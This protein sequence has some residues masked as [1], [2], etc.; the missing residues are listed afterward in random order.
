MH[1]YI[2]F[3]AMNCEGIM[4][5]I[6]II[7]LHILH[8]QSFKDC[9]K[10]IF[11]IERE[12]EREPNSEI[13]HSRRIL[14]LFEF[15]FFKTSTAHCAQYGSFHLTVQSYIF[16]LSSFKMIKLLREKICLDQGFVYGLVLSGSG[17][18]LSEQ[19]GYG[20]MNVLRPDPESPVLKMF[21][22]FYDDF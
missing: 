1:I 8:I 19:T 5:T 4:Y 16:F 20:S 3:I 6:C 2:Y 12:R 9:I 18:I 21:H 11:K 13:K 15:E 17:S 14:S 10:Y 7:R 22:L